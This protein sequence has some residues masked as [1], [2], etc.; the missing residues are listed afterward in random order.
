MDAK[1][2][3][4]EYS[5]IALRSGDLAIVQAPTRLFANACVVVMGEDGEILLSVRVATFDEG[6]VVVTRVIV[7]SPTLSIRDPSEV[8]AE[9]RRVVFAGR[10]P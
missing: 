5:N 8:Q 6:G 1:T 3:M 4:G 2:D 9:C 7:D 10:R